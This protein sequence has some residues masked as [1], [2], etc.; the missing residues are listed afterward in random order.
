MKRENIETI[1]GLFG[2][3]VAAFLIGWFLGQDRQSRKPVEL[4]AEWFGMKPDGVNDNTLQMQTA[5]NVASHLLPSATIIF[6]NGIYR[7]EGKFV[8]QSRTNNP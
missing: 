1:I 3:I 8:N 5:I 2:A 6:S 4:Q 7:I